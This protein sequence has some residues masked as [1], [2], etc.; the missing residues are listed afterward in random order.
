[1]RSVS[2]WCC[3]FLSVLILPAGAAKP[4]LVQNA[5]FET[6]EGAVPAGWQCE[7]KGIYTRDATTAHSGTA[8]LKWVNDDPGRLARAAQWL[9]LVPQPGASYD[10]GVWAKTAD[11]RR[12]QGQG[13]G[14]GIQVQW[15]DETR[16]Q[17]LGWYTGLPAI[18]GTTDWTWVGVDLVTFP[19]EA[20]AF[21][22]VCFVFWGFTGTAWF[23]DVTVHETIQP[24][25]TAFLLSP[26]YRGWIYGAQPA[27][28]RLRVRLN[29]QDHDFQLRDVTLTAAI[30]PQ[31]AV[32]PVSVRPKSEIVDLTLPADRL[33]PGDFTLTV[34]LQTGQ[35]PTVLATNSFPLTRLAGAV[36]AKVWVNRDQQLM[37]DGQPFFPLGMYTGGMDDGAMTRFAD[38][39]FNCLMIY[40]S[41]RTE[42][43]DL[44]Q[45]HRLRVIYSLNNYFAGEKQAPAGVTTAAEEEQVLRARV[46]AMR[47]HP[48]LLAWYLNDEL[49]S[50]Y[51]P[52]LRD[53][54][55]WVQAEDADHPA[56]SVLGSPYSLRAYADT[57]DI[58]GSD[59]YPVPFE[60]ASKAGAWAQESVRQL[61]GA[62][63]VWMVPQA[64]NWAH[65]Y[66]DERKDKSRQPSYEELRSM[67]WQCLCEGATGLVYYTWEEMDKN[68]GMWDALKR[69]TAEIKDAT[70]ILLGPGPAPA[71][72]VTGG[73]WLHWLAKRYQ[74]KLYLF[75]VNDGDGEGAFTVTLPK[76]PASVR[77][78]DEKLLAVTDGTKQ[79]SVPVTERDFHQTL[80]KLEM[81]G[82]EIS[83]K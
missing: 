72:E 16:K 46:R 70:P 59:P 34:N 35:P 60:P 19:P 6:A 21:R 74:G 18:S 63:P 65:Y 39:A 1:M 69:V 33:P 13:R 20:K 75:V 73:S 62:R 58:L 10:F 26:N 56:W 43:L 53:H 54:F 5:G 3:L 82:Y 17:L 78:L 52:R 50:F 42:M 64:M 36:T 55:R 71:I 12:V 24:A 9:D 83:E 11:C 48:A 31:Q 28:V 25:M 51:L 2:W 76:T 40:G 23:D 14:V 68:P 57:S 22:V 8:S 7:G 4:N 49:P 79:P 47:P 45:R 27:P 30:A 77:M 44:A 61:E 41:P 66:T 37:V 15:F 29:P 38:S 81:R 80:G 67:S 32:K